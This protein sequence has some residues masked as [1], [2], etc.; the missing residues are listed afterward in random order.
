MTGP[1]SFR[2][3][4]RTLQSIFEG[5]EESLERF[6]RTSEIQLKTYL[7]ES[8]TQIQ[9]SRPP[10]GRWRSLDA[11]GWYTI[12]TGRAEDFLTVDAGGPI[13]RVFSLIEATRSD[14]VIGEWIANVRGLDRC[15]LSRAQLLHWAGQ[16]EW[17]QRGVGIR[18]DDGLEPADRAGNFSMKAW[19][20]DREVI[21]GI[22]KVIELA[23]QQLAVSSARWQRVSGGR[24]RLLAETYSDG[25]I[26][27]NRAEDVDEVMNFSQALADDYRERINRANSL[28][29]NSLAPFEF[30][31]AQEI[32]LESFAETVGAGRGPMRLW[33]VETKQERDFR[34]FRGVDMHTWDRIY[35]DLTPRYGC[36]TVPGKGCVNAAPRIA[37]IQGEDN[38]GKTRVLA[39]GVDLFA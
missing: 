12:D 27:F 14:A 1:E 19:H 25:K 21:P 3:F 4:A 30:E 33:L 11:P 36:L 29:N 17:T 6:Q 7:V 28:R 37:A 5:N 18:F 10:L 34:R 38:A 8:N 2:E 13:W 23:Q 16:G 9:Q 20:G 32:S 15:W 39:D 24:T 26:T 22:G 31:F 35:F